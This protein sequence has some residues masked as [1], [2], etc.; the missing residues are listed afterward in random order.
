MNAGDTIVFAILLIAVCVGMFAVWMMTLGMGGDTK[1]NL[2]PRTFQLGQGI[3]FG[4]NDMSKPLTRSSI[5]NLVGQF[6]PPPRP[7]DFV[8]CPMKGGQVV[9]C[10]IEID[11]TGQHWTAKAIPISTSKDH[12]SQRRRK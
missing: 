1:T 11:H 6:Q 10:F 12:E 2:E 3:D 4:D 5:Y 8:E 9:L 7:G